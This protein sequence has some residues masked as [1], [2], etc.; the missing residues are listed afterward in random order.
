[1][2]TVSGITPPVDNA[3]TVDSEHAVND[4]YLKLGT[5]AAGS[6]AVA[7][8]TG[9]GME[10][11]K[12]PG[13]TQE[14]KEAVKAAKIAKETANIAQSTEDATKL[15]EAAKTAKLTANTLGAA[16]ALKTNGAIDAGIYVFEVATAAPE[17]R[18][19]TALVKGVSTATNVS[20]NI[21]GMSTLAAAGAEGTAAAA[22]G[23]IIGT[24]GTILVPMAVMAA[25]YSVNRT[26]SEALDA[27]KAADEADKS[28]KD[29]A[30]GDQLHLAQDPGKSLQAIA[31]SHID[32]LKQAGMV[33]TGSDG[34]NIYDFSSVEKLQQ[35]RKIVTDK[36]ASYQNA[37]DADDS[38]LR[39][40]NPFHWYNREDDVANEAA[41]ARVNQAGAQGELKV[42][43]EIITFSKNAPQQVTEQSAAPEISQPPVSQPLPEKT[44]PEQ[45]QGVMTG[46]GSVL[47][48]IADFIGNI[49]HSI[50]P[51]APDAQAP[52]DTNTAAGNAQ[53]GG[54]DY[55]PPL[56]PSGTPSIAISNLQ[57]VR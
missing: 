51:G 7:K 30:S 10:A 5:A 20:M 16:K 42:L 46:I 34:K 39:K 24:G 15:A 31:H 43:D 21:A 47:R 22:G 18:G 12:A 9:W 55:T 6:I 45:S 33:T 4:V 19:K 36:A 56:I 29:I 48:S 2:T 1:M 25:S 27:W 44:Q 50:F 41:S 23:A 40:L 8:G 49:F 13:L 17:D 28:L 3:P 37:I 11:L 35:L 14:A 52:A 32:D 26:A 57:K 53:T 38:L 54:A